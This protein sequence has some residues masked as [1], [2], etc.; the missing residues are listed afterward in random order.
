MKEKIAFLKRL[1][2]KKKEDIEFF[3]KYITYDK[4]NDLIIVNIPSMGGNTY[5]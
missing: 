3:A 1:G 2:L 5:L 4:K